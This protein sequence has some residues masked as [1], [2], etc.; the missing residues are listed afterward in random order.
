ML[1]LKNVMAALAGAPL[2]AAMIAEGAVAQPQFPSF[3]YFVP[4]LA[5][6]GGPVYV[7][8]G[9]VTQ[10][11]QISLTVTGLACEQGAID[12]FNAAGVIAV[13]GKTPHTKVGDA[14]T[15]RRKFD[16]YEATVNFGSLVMV[17]EGVGVAQLFPAS[18]ANGLGG[19]NVPQGLTLPL[20][21]LSALGFPPFTATNARVRLYVADN[22]YPD[23]TGGFVVRLPAS[24][25]AYGP[26]AN[27]HKL[28]QVNG[29]CDWQSWMRGAGPC[30]TT[31]ASGVPSQV[32]GA[33]LGFVYRSSR[34]GQLTMLFGDTIGIA[35]LPLQPV[36]WGMND[37]NTYIAFRA[38]DAPGLTPAKPANIGQLSITFATP[39]QFIQPNFENNGGPVPMGSDDVPSSGIRL[40]HTN[41]VMIS[42]GAT[43]TGNKH[44]MS[45]SV[46]AQQNSDGS[47]IA[48]ATHISDVASGGHFVFV[49]LAELPL[50]YARQIGLAD[51]AV[52]LM[53]NGNFRSE[54]I[55]L[56]YIP[57]SQFRIDKAKPAMQYLVGYDANG[58]PLWCP[59]A[60]SL[61]S[62][63]PESQAIPLVPDNTAGN[64]SLYYDA[65]LALWL[66]TWDG[67]R[68]SPAT[69]G[70]YF[71]TA[72]AP[73]GP[74]SSPQR[75]FNA[76]ADNGYG[77]FMHYVAASHACPALAADAGP[78]GPI[79]GTN[80]DPFNGTTNTMPP[81]NAMTR[82]GAV[83]APF[84]IPGLAT[85][86]GR[87]LSLYY[88]I[89]TWNPYAVVL[90]QSTFSI[91]PPVF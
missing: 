14:A 4:A 40:K 88:D 57:A 44:A 6:K 86:S 77:T 87:Q 59:A 46:L 27:T 36:T 58:L 34:A 80:D 81:E 28:A 91:A 84:I 85:V 78:A 33:D 23:N 49:A 38:A 90:M 17:I 51:P 26:A 30:G 8:A 22:Y 18:A 73:W 89:S 70:V 45:Y 64:L 10:N 71:S 75:I 66:L 42:T 76:C 12:C 2:V 24:Q 65:D 31:L 67:G 3:P 68:G 82:N 54:S 21:P 74:W 25:L 53:G 9:S 47:Y 19:P 29:P 61:C 1:Q 60:G 32:L 15:F 48:G 56:A 79:I 69:E 37:P 7:I 62:P 55:Y 5:E 83:Y 50:P 13:A 41:Y 63:N 11:T 35:K 72:F 39:T 16:G 20:T 52:L 43:Q